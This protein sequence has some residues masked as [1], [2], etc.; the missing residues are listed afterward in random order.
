MGYDEA[1]RKPALT[2][3]LVLLALVSAPGAVHA[4]NYPG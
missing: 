4:G 1:V 3:F 2:A